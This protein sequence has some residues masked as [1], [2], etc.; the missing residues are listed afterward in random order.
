MS[1]CSLPPNCWPHPL[2]GNQTSSVHSFL[3]L[4]Y[5][6]QM[7]HFPTTAFYCVSVRNMQ[8]EAEAA[9]LYSNSPKEEWCQMLMMMSIDQPVSRMHSSQCE[10]ESVLCARVLTICLLCLSMYVGAQGARPFTSVTSPTTTTTTSTVCIWTW[11]PNWG[12]KWC[13]SVEDAPLVV[14]LWLVR[15]DL[16]GWFG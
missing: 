6:R 3:G 14:R 15:D 11:R 1:Y 10:R 16:N 5:Y 12:G 8:Q 9:L 7:T 13:A 2:S 4:I